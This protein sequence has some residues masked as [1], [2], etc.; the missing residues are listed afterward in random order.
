MAWAA[1][2]PAPE[3]VRSH[4]S[5]RL[6]AMR[7]QWAGLGVMGDH[8]EHGHAEA[9]REHG[10]RCEGTHLYR[11]KRGRGRVRGE[12]TRWRFRGER[13]K[14]YAESLASGEEKCARIRCEARE[15]NSTRAP[16]SNIRSSS[17]TNAACW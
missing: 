17:R 13:R 3:A 8:L 16:E 7:R 5:E 4:A 2:K 6:N 15:I 11:G 10:E 12:R 1:A 9:T 14:E